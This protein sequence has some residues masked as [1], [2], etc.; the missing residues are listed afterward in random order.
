MILLDSIHIERIYKNYAVVAGLESFR[1]LSLL[2][3]IS[4]KK[5]LFFHIIIIISSTETLTQF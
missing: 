2:S 1:I 4:E 5:Q 3:S